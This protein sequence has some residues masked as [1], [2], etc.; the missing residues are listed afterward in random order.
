VRH[1]APEHLLSVL[2]QHPAGCAP[3]TGAGFDAV[4]ARQELE[5]RG[6]RI[7]EVDASSRAEAAGGEALWRLRCAHEHFSPRRF[8]A[9]RTSR[10]GATLQVWEECDSTNSLAAA[11]A[12]EAPH[13][14][15]WLAEEQRRGRGRQGRRWSCPAHGGLL[16]SLLLRPATAAAERAQLLPLA[17]ALG[18]CE[19]LR[20]STRRDVRVKWPNDLV[21]GG[22]KLGGI[23]VEARLADRPYAIV[24]CGINVRVDAELLRREGIP[25]A[26]SLDADSE[27]LPDREAILAQVLACVEEHYEAWSASRHEVVLERWPRYDALHGRRVRVELAARSTLGT[28]TGIAADGSLEVRLDDGSTRRFAAGEVHL[29]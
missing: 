17:A 20:R 5:R 12:A 1:D 9:L 27:A 21:V 22:Q 29:R 25:Q 23:L 18:V 8:A 14:S 26:S 16:F 2:V 7:D 24:G 13:G 6:H 4:A 19:G 15:V 3:P 28:A 11:A 10:F